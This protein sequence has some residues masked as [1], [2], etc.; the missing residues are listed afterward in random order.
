MKEEQ[1]YDPIGEWLIREKG[2]QRDKY[3]QGY[4]K[5]IQVGDIRP[6]V[7]AIRYEIITD[8]TYPVIHFH[9]YIVEVK[10]DGKGLNELLGKIMRVKRRARTS[11]EWMSGLH[12]VRFY[13]AYPTEQVSSEVFEICEEEGIGI[14]RLQVI[15]ETTVNVYEV[16]RPREIALNGM[17]H[18]S[19]RSPGVFEDSINRIGYLR[20]MFQ[21]PSKLYDDFIRPKIKEYKQKL[22]R[23]KL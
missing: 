7:F 2:C 16:L 10:C 18:N 17:S 15:D 19:Q 1:L 23:G 13:I 14:L 6:D 22:N 5:N 21:R 4:L 8:R 12:T 9:G 3:S 11:K 20:Q